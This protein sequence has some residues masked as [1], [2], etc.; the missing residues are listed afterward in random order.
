MTPEDRERMN[1]LCQLIQN[2]RDPL[3]FGALVVELDE[4][5]ATKEEPLTGLQKP[6]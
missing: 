6:N 3:A 5:L 4:L 2:E 1:L